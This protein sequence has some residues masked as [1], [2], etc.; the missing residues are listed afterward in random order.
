AGSWATIYGT[1]MTVSAMTFN[2]LMGF[3]GGIIGAWVVTRDPFWMMSGA[4]GGIISCAG[5]LDL[6]WPP[7]AFAI[8]FAGGAVMKP[9]AVF[10]EEKLKVDDAVGAVTVHG[11]LGIWGLLAV[12]IF[13]SGYPALQTPE[14]TEMVYIS[15]FGQLVG[16]VV[17]FLLGFAPGYALSYVLKMLGL[18]RVS[19]E[20]EIAGLDLTKVPAKA[21]PEGI[22]APATPAE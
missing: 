22:L 1:P 21:Y 8:A 19:E 18:L 16:A 14:G 3:A 5:G 17:M 2:I 11:V 13:A 20:A 4:L 12:G 6:W 10:I 7:L 15:F 9:A